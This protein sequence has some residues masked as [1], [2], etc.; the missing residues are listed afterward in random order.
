MKRGKN[1]FP[2]VSRV[3][4]RHGKLR[5]RFRRG[6]FSAYLHGEYGSQQFVREY[7]AACEGV[8]KPGVARPNGYPRTSFN[9]LIVE[10]M[11]SPD[12]KRLAPITQRNRHGE[13]EWLR[14]QVGD[15]PFEMM[16]PNHVEKLMDRKTGADA[17]NKVKKRLSAL[18]IFAQRLG[19]R[20]Q[21]PGARRQTAQDQPRGLLHLD[22]G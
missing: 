15:L 4:D 11:R 17:A 8:R 14:E 21:Q 5:W 10:Y 1:P 2:G 22:R 12:F 16:K 18:F 3:I 20:D 13:L 7:A 6:S 9:W 19:N